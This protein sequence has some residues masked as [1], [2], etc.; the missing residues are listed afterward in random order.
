MPVEESP[1][2]KLSR[3]K[4]LERGGT[5]ALALPLLGLT[6]PV[7][8][9]LMPLADE[10]LV[11]LFGAEFASAAPSLR[12]LLA[13]AAV[14]SVGAGCLTENLAVDCDDGNACTTTDVCRGG[15]CVGRSR[16]RRGD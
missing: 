2:E 13:A 5:S 4:L 14:V 9:A 7:A 12:W 6:L 1:R 16:I 10:V 3:R 11:L 8:L 15:G